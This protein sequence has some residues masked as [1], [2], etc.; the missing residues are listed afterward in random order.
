[1]ENSSTNLNDT[2]EYR[3]QQEL[4][5][6]KPNFIELF[7]GKATMSKTFERAGYNIFSIDNR[8]RKNTC[9]PT[10]KAD[11]L[12][13]S[14]AHIPFQTVNVIWASPPC[15]AFS[16][17]AGNIYFK[18]NQFTEKARYFLQL[19]QQTCLLIE[20]L[21]PTIW[22]IENPN[23]RLK[24]IPWFKAWVE[25]NNGAHYAITLDAYGFQTTKPTSIFTNCQALMT[26]PESNYG[27]GYKCLKK[28]VNL[29]T[30]QRQSTP[31]ALADD[32]LY[33]SNIHLQLGLG[34]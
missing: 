20:A 13:I 10:L 33:Y 21:S 30:V 1:M 27:R 31:Q 2:V 19:L 15:T 14:P 6:S 18:N 29:T 7:C 34:G 5:S 28:F 23:C 16:K 11:I 32:I 25:K 26:R 17:A 8:Y 4:R 3:S 9:E 12:K 22:W 24:N